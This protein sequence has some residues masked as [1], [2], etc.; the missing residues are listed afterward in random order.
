MS[1]KEVS[2]VKAHILTRKGGISIRK[3]NVEINIP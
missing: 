1:G 2:W 3:S